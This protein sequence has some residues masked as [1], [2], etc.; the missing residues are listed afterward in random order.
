MNSLDIIADIAILTLNNPP[1][2]SLTEPEFISKH[3]LN[4]FISEKCL[5]A[6]IIKGAGR[7]FSSGADLQSVKKMAENGSL[8][9]KLNNGKELLEYIY[10]MNIPVIAAIEGVCFGGGLEIALSSHIRIA[11]HKAL[12]AFPESNH[13]LMPGLTGTYAVKR[14]LTMGKSLNMLLCGDILAADAAYKLGLI[15]FLSDA[16]N[17][18]DDALIMAKKMTEDKPVKT[19]NNIVTAIKNAYVFDKSEAL[20]EETRL[21]CEL[22]G[23]IDLDE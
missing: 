12:L 6:L 22:A 23:N 2:N 8:E 21:F 13:N 10:G 3:E 15:D 7:H 17:S 14:F 16:K 4:D 9:S 20:Q 19:I 18:F 11:S 1:D 5:K